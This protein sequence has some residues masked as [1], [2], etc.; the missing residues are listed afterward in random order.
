MNT[1]WTA[2]NAADAENTSALLAAENSPRQNENATV[3]TTI[4]PSR[5]ILFVTKF[6]TM[7]A[8]MGNKQARLMV[9]KDTILRT[10]LGK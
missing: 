5:L 9:A 8:M 10:L 2:A 6:D 1:T 4:K 3:K 7:I